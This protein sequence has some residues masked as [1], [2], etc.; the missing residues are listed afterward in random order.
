MNPIVAE[1]SLRIFVRRRNLHGPLGSASRRLTRQ[2]L[3]IL[4]GQR[5]CELAARE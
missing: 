5:R 1:S 4:R 2:L 3:E